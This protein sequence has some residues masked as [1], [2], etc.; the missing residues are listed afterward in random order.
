VLVGSGVIEKIRGV[1]PHALLDLLP[2][3]DIADNRDN[4]QTRISTLE[5]EVDEGEATLRPV[6][7]EERFRLKGGKLTAEFRPDGPCRA[8]DEDSLPMNLLSQPVKVQADCP[9]AE[10]I[11]RPNLSGSCRLRGVSYHASYEPTWWKRGIV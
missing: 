10:K 9:S 5:F 11:L 7:E 3:H 2:I 4:L 6:E 1:G 8:S